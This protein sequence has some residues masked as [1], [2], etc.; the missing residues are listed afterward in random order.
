MQN[1]DNSVMTSENVYFLNAP[2]NKSALIALSGHA[3]LL[4]AA[5][6]TGTVHAHEIKAPA[7][8][9][10]NFSPRNNKSPI[11]RGAIAQTVDSIHSFDAFVAN[12]KVNNFEGILIQNGHTTW[13]EPY[14]RAI[15]LGV[16]AEQFGKI[17]TYA[18]AIKKNPPRFNF[19]TGYN[20]GTFCYEALKCADVYFEDAE[21][22]EMARAFPNEIYVRAV[23]AHNVLA[24]EKIDFR[25]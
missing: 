22:N 12:C 4:L 6:S 15:R 7:Y 24:F 16:T 23:S 19:L 14:K 17:R 3:S 13:H 2:D 11:G 20:C 10:Y 5:G 21:G 25:K 1:G 8:E 18:Q 9:L